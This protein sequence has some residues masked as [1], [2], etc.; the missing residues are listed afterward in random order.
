MYAVEYIINGVRVASLPHAGTLEA[1]RLIASDGVQRHRADYAR[2]VH[3]ESQSAE[4]W[5]PTDEPSEQ[6]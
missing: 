3:N 6:L 1:A 5:R 2:I 4:V